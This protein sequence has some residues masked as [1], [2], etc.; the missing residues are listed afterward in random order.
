MSSPPPPVP[1][2]LLGLGHLGKIH[3]RCAGALPAD[4]ALV[5]AYDVDASARAAFAKTHPD[6]VCDTL[7]GVW[8][9]LH[10]ARQASGHTAVDIVTATPAHAALATAALERGHHVFVEK[11]ITTTVADAERVVALAAARGLV[12]QVGH[13]ERFNPA[14][15]IAEAGG[16]KPVFVEAHR[17]AQFNPRAMDISVV[18][19]L[20][21]HDLDLVLHLIDAPLE[22]VSASGVAVVGD[23]IDIA[24]AR[25]DFT[26]GATA[27]LTAS[28]ISLK[29]MRKLRLFERDAYV[30]VDLLAKSTEVVRL[31]A[32]DPAA[33]GLFQLPT[34]SGL[35][36]V[37]M[38]QPE[39]S[40]VNAIE[41]ELREFAAA[42]REGRPA[43]VTGDDGRRA[44]EVAQRILADIESRSARH[45]S[46]LSL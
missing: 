40:P 24:N 41:E 2:A 32:H 15:A 26:N 6:Q 33:P 23:T 19:D 39:V 31:S 16:L 25:L 18:L 7:D 34:T 21:I 12:V 3:A 17:L 22:R 1:F 44:L 36:E 35:R 45:L 42:I 30:S 37:V 5:A 28:R 29:D 8:D 13:V 9:R 27:N 11:P 43:R 38:E 20:M 4:L 14:F 10:S 46:T